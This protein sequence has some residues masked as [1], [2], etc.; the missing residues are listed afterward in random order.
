MSKLN[1]GFTT[2]CALGMLVFGASIDSTDHFGV[3][4]GGLIFCTAWCI[5]SALMSQRRE[6]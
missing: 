4:F 2:M 1:K 5:G 6:P 3:I